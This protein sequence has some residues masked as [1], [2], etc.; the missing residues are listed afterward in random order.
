M[1]FSVAGWKRPARQAVQPG[2][3]RKTAQLSP[4][5]ADF[6]FGGFPDVAEHEDAK[7]G[8]E[9]DGENTADDAAHESGAD[10]DR[11]DDGER[12]KADAVAHD[13]GRDDEAFEHLNESEEGDDEQGMEPIAKLNDREDDGGDDTDDDS[14]KGNDAEQTGSHPEEEGVIEADEH[15]ADGEENAIGEGDEDLATEKEN[16]VIV[17]R[18]D[19]EDH[20]AFHGRFLDG[21]IIGPA[22]FDTAFFEEEVE[23]VNRDEG[24][25]EEEAE[26]FRDASGLGDKPGGNRGGGFAKPGVEGGF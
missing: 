26:P 22:S 25:A 10:H 23:E 15:K 4:A 21:E 9:G 2:I 19:D 13:L 5:R 1:A 18:L 11:D 24:E 14:E 12:M 8:G 20:F 17:D 7:S 6:G 16:E 3:N